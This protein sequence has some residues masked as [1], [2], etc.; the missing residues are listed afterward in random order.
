MIINIEPFK[1]LAYQIRADLQGANGHLRRG[2]RQFAA[3]IRS[4]WAQR[5]DRYSKGGG[6]WKPL[7]P[8]TL[9][10]RRKGKGSGLQA[11][12]LVDT[13]TL[14]GSFNSQRGMIEADI[15][16]GLRIGFGGA[17]SH[18]AGMTIP[19]LAQIHQGGGPRL[20]ARPIIVE[21]DV[22]T[23]AAGVAD[24]NRAIAAIAR[25]TRSA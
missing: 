12:I 19:R 10:R 11:A 15:P 23:V 1:H 4:F 8:S 18:S 25:E 3:R 21:P 17:D 13:G 22:R 6:D 2:L 5:F 7:A 24:V 9:R 16:N 20:P 14:K